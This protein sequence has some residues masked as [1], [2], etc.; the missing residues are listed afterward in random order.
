MMFVKK[1]QAPIV[2]LFVKNYHMKYKEYYSLSNLEATSFSHSLSCVIG[3]KLVS[4]H[5]LYFSP[6]SKSLVK[7]RI[8]ELLFI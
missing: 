7:S 5:D 3:V 2:P 1:I 4:K 8:P 6:S